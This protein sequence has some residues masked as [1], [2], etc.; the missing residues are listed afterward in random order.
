MVGGAASVVEVFWWNV[1]SDERH[2]AVDGLLVERDEVVVAF[3]KR[4]L[5]PFDD[6]VDRDDG[7]AFEQ[8]A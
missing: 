2:A 7:A 5:E 4:L 8:R 1:E 6:G 3:G